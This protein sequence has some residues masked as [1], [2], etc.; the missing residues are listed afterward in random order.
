MITVQDDIATFRDAAAAQKMD[1][2]VECETLPTGSQRSQHAKA[3]GTTVSTFDS[4]AEPARPVNGASD[5]YV[6]TTRRLDTASSGGPRLDLETGR[7]DGE[8]Y[9]LQHVRSAT[10]TSSTQAGTT[11]AIETHEAAVGVA[12]RPVR[13]FGSLGS[14]E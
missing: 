3:G 10:S 14:Y 2:D 13:Q 12:H 8:S 9:E 1:E 7:H 4:D 11:T 5:A 6:Y